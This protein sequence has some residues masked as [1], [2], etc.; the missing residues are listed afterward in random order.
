MRVPVWYDAISYMTSDVASSWRVS[1]HE[2][3]SGVNFFKRSVEKFFT[4]IVGLTS[5]MSFV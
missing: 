1:F 4:R 3:I 2:R 5:G